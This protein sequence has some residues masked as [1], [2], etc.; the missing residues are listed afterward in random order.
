M[1]YADKMA[2]KVEGLGDTQNIYEKKFEVTNEWCLAINNIDY[3]R[4]TL[5]PFTRD[6]GMTEIIQKICDIKSP[7]DAQRCQD[8]LE[9]VIAN[10]IDTVR[11]KI[12]ELLETVVSKVRTSKTTTKKTVKKHLKTIKNS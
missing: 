4:E 2:A 7:L 1:F 3:V 10:A 11:N 9:N 5:E 6:L 12:I 8:T